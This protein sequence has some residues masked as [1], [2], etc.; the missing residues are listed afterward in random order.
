MQAPSDQKRK[1]I[2]HDFAK[3]A[4]LTALRSGSPPKSRK[5]VYDLIENQGNLT[6]LLTR[7]VRLMKPT[8]TVGMRRQSPKEQT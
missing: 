4:A 6:A 5:Q 2:V 7:P 8:S 1:K 3:W